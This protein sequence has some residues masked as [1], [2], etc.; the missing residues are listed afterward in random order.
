MSVRRSARLVAL[1][2]SVVVHGVAIGQS[3]E[4]PKSVAFDFLAGQQGRLPGTCEGLSYPGPSGGFVLAPSGEEVP[5]LLDRLRGIRFATERATTS[6][7][8][9]GPRVWLRSGSEFAASL[10]ERQGADGVRAAFVGRGGA[11]DGVAFGL[12]LQFVR[13]LQ[14]RALTVEES[15][16]FVSARGRPDE[17]LDYVFVEHQGALRRQRV[18]VLRFVD[19]PEG[20]A[21][22]LEF[23]G[24]TYEIATSRL[25]AIV[26]ADARGT[27]PQ[28]LA[29]PYVYLPQ[30]AAPPLRGKLVSLSE[31]LVTI[32]TAEGAELALPR[33]AVGEIGVRSSRVAT[34]S[35]LEPVR[36]E[37]TPA[38]DRE[39][40]WLRDRAPGGDGIVLGGT[41]YETGLVLPP[42][43]RLEFSVPGGLRRLL[44]SVGIDDRAG[45]LGHAVFRI[46]AGPTVLFE[47]VIAAGDDAVAVDVTIPD[48]VASFGIETDYG[49]RFD[50]GDHCAFAD[51]RLVRN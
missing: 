50:L 21:L 32:R 27:A 36:V 4:A 38:L 13:A 43:T 28:P 7:S 17:T 26:F 20:P 16:A 33:S 45:P 48:G 6:G 19:A 22:E 12:P 18:R 29:P 1:A 31:A 3:D 37:Y 10:A 14:L 9:D 23:G 40:P 44:A 11:L 35:D 47:R 30:R 2:A 8:E 5:D 15:E 24:K 25:A 41:K 42:R 39:W 46:V 49:D 51:A 34:L